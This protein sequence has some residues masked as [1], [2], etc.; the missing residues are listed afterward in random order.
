MFSVIIP[1]YNHEKFIARSIDSVLAQDFGDFEL[2]VVDDGSRDATAEKVKAYDDPRI[3]LIEQANAGEAGARNAGIARATRPWL[4]FLDGDDYWFP[5][6]LAEAK[7]VIE[8]HPEAGFVST[9]MVSGS[10]WMA[11]VPTG[12]SDII[13]CTSFFKLA[14]KELLVVIP[15]SAVV[16]SDVVKTVGGFSSLRRRGTDNEYW[17]RVGLV[18]PF[19]HS[20]VVTVYYYKHP[21][22][23]MATDQHR[24][25][26]APDDI[27]E[28]W[29]SVAV[30]RSVQDDPKYHDL[31]PYFEMY[32]RQATYLSMIGY[33]SRREHDVA[34]RLAKKLPGRRLDRA[35]IIATLSVLPDPV[36]NLLLDVR[37][38]LRRGFRSKG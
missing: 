9:S 18:T 33:I 35:G 11:A 21:D 15:S 13:E 24:R 19:A 29:P 32:E 5:N 36:W 4:A 23:I 14:G 27:D 17:V 6:H 30:V 1:A 2:I 10:E 3:I 28:M 34:R 38:V 12:G 8:R 7:R 25:E 37:G 22:S 16:R 31:K 26:I 20:H